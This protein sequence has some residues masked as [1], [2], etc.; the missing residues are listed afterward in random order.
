MKNKA[1]TIVVSTSG[2]GGHTVPAKWIAQELVNR[3]KDNQVH[4]I[5]SKSD[6]TAHVVEEVVG[7]ENYHLVSTG[8]YRRYADDSK[9]RKL[10][11][12]E[13]N[14]KNTQDLFRFVKGLSS[15]VRLLKKIKPD[16]VFIKGGAVAL[17][18]G[19]AANLLKIPLVTHDS[20]TVSGMANKVVGKKAVYNLVGSSAGEYP[21]YSPGKIRVVGVP[22]SSK[23][24]PVNKRQQKAAK[25]DLGFDDDKPLVFIAGGSLGSKSINDIV[26]AAGKDLVKDDI[27]ILHQ[28]G[29]KYIDDV[30]KSD[31]SWD[32]RPFIDPNMMP[33]VFAAC[34][35]IVSRAGATFLT[36]IGQSETP[37]IIIPA[38]QLYDQVSNGKHLSEG[39]F[40]VVIDE[41]SVTKRP[42]IL[43]HNITK[44]INNPKLS[45]EYAKKLATLHNPSAI[46][47][48]ADLIIEAAE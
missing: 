12:L 26:V 22:V 42:Q 37:A 19:I 18:V 35:L 48:V 16:V 20:D 23:F 8:K 32:V 39:K 34:D 15:S 30:S 47:D 27:Q 10:L 4:F 38:K 41:E 14:L 36:E 6:S 46:N 29:T 11:D 17:P 24:K 33:T 28:T 40:V 43:H 45:K 5:G 2:S 13:T 3:S 9:L 1:L 21:S 44:L 31:P 25:K 7:S